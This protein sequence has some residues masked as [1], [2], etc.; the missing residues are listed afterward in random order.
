MELRSV[1][2]LISFFLAATVGLTLFIVILAVRALVKRTKKKSIHQYSHVEIYNFMNR[3]GS[4]RAST[5]QI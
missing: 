3:R 2:F 1:T 4:K 5:S